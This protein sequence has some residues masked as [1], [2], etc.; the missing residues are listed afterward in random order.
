MPECLAEDD[1]LGLR[2]V[3]A[4]CI[5]FFRMSRRAARVLIFVVLPFV[6]ESLTASAITQPTSRSVLFL[7]Q[8]FPNRP[9]DIA[10]TSSIRSTL[11]AESGVPISFY[12]EHLDSNRFFG[13][14]YEVATVSFLREKYSGKPIDIVV[15]LGSD[16]L[17]FISRRR[18]ELWPDAP[19][20]FAAIDEATAARLA[21]PPNVTGVTMQLSLQVME[22]AARVVV[23]N[24]RRLAIVGDALERQ[25][26]YRHFKDEIPIVAARLEIIDLQNLP[27]AELEKPLGALPDFTAVIYTGIY[28]DTKG[29]SYVPAELVA[30]IA[31]WANRPLVVNVESYLGKGAVGGYIVLPELIGQQAARIALRILNGENASSI[32]VGKVL[33]PPIFEWPALQRWGINENSLPPGSKILFRPLTAWE[34]YYWQIILIA[35][36]LLVQFL[37][38]AGLLHQR[39]R[40]HLAELEGRRRMGELAHMNRSAAIGEMS[41]SIAHEINQPLAGIV[42]NAGSALRFLDSTPPQFEGMRRVLNMILRDGDRASNVIGTIRSMFKKD[43]QDKQAIRINEP[44]RETLALLRSELDDRGIS[45]N[46]VLTEGLPQILGNRIQLQQ[47]VLNLIR[48][49][50]EAMSSVNDRAHVLRVRSEADESGDVIVTIG[51]SGPGI[52]ADSLARIFEPFFTTKSDGMGMGLSICRS[53]VEAHDGQLTAAPAKP[54]GMDFQ[55]VLPRH[56]TVQ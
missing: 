14:G 53:I 40:R 7:S 1:V 44:I 39:R 27:L 48:N 31:R 46:V 24:L 13:P 29:L 12:M 30:R 17:D 15:A 6:A 45:A 20:V 33:S 35:A 16:A 36:A 41:A 55:I 22:A 25:T 52:D 26:F 51:D 5:C 32:A 8:S 18:A 38:I 23:P 9:V 50:A 54:S 49:A 42:M 10:L 43:I 19:V 34:Q 47:V 21:L 11:N 37:L 3:V 4:Q 56:E 2:T 28:Y